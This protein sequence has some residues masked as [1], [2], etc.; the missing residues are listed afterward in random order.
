[1]ID[2]DSEESCEECDGLLT[3]AAV[4]DNTDEE[5]VAQSEAHDNVQPGGPAPSNG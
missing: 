2:D 5:E 3:Q 4:V 1:V